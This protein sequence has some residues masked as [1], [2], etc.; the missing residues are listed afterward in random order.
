MFLEESKT[1]ALNKNIKFINTYCRFDNENK[2]FNVTSFYI[3]L[4][5][6]NFK[7]LEFN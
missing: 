3:K 7:E 1:Y 5:K 4:E 6:L 2:T